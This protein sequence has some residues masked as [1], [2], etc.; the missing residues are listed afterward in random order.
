MAAKPAIRL[1][2]ALTILMLIT[3]TS[4]AGVRAQEEGGD[5]IGKWLE[6]AKIAWSYFD[7]GVG[8]NPDTGLSR[9]SRYWSFTTDWDLGGYIIAII[10]AE[11]M[12]ILPIEGDWGA[13]D[14]LEKVLHF[15]ET[16]KLTPYGIP[17]WCYSTENGEPRKGG[18]T[19]VSDFG[20]LLIALYILKR[21]RPNL[22]DRIDAIV[23]RVNYARLA[24]DPAAWRST[25]G[26]YKY[27]VAHGFK[28]FGFDKYYP[29]KKALEAFEEI[30]N[31]RHISVYGVSLPVTE[32]TS[33]PIL[34]TVFELNPGEDFMDYAHRVYLAQESRYKSTGM[35][36]A[37]SEGNTGLPDPS[38]IY[39]WIVTPRGKT[40]VITPKQTT[41][42]IFTR[43]AFG[44]H[45]IYNTPYT[46]SLVK[47]VEEKTDLRNNVRL[48]RSLPSKGFLEGVRE[49]G[50]VVLELIANTQVMIIEAAYYALKERV[51]SSAD[52]LFEKPSGELR[53][54]EEVKFSLNYSD[55]T[56]LKHTCNLT[57]SLENLAT[58]YATQYAFNGTCNATISWKPPVD[59][60]YRA[61]A[62]LIADYLLFNKII[63]KGF[64]IIV[65]SPP[66]KREVWIVEAF[67]PDHVRTEEEFNVTALIKHDF[68]DSTI[69]VKLLVKDGGGGVLAE[70]EVVKVSGN[71]SLRLAVGVR[72]PD[73]EGN[74]TLSLVPAYYDENRWF[75]VSNRSVSLNVVVEKTLRN[76]TFTERTIVKKKVVLVTMTRAVTIKEKILTTCTVTRTVSSTTVG[77]MLMPIAILICSI[78]LLAVAVMTSIAG[79]RARRSSELG[80]A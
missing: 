69:P 48:K 46:R 10:L 66:P 50:E 40:W 1:M 28:F 71:G 79:R 13:E 6:W 9:A 8:V 43:A 45:A 4:L 32:V 65:G 38:Y 62:K 5:E 29:V 47:Y 68:G 16:R 12:G 27:Y 19:N 42:I 57:I 15:L 3:V 77:G 30:K 64:D 14:R 70:S 23:H 74:L 56:P 17:A 41:P 37:W 78:S 53:P 26:F 49:N 75:E 58:S 39:E 7:P 61:T 76:Q 72:A 31:G 11:R 73:E 22:A 52:L 54:G 67:S 35:L 51:K 24:E 20:R 25:S 2:T 59:G 80:Y 21:Y 60:V 33:E 34:H 55:P 44:L 18:S 36:T 63:V